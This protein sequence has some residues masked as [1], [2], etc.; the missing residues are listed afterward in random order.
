MEYKVS[1]KSGTME[2]VLSGQFTFADNQQF[3]EI[4]AEFR[5][6]DITAIAFDLSGIEFIDSAALGMFLLARD[7]AEENSKQLI[8]RKPSGQVKK[9]L[10]ISKFH[11]L[12]SIEP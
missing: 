10:E 1:Q 6:P 2:V 9:M 7:E 4:I 5:N 8:L 3:R 12:F 11:S